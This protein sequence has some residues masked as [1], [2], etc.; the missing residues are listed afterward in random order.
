MHFWKSLYAVTPLGRPLTIS[1]QKD[2]YLKFASECVLES[3]CFTCF[4]IARARTFLNEKPSNMARCRQQRKY[5]V[6]M[7]N[8]CLSTIEENKA[9]LK[10]NKSKCYLFRWR[11]TIGVALILHLPTDKQRSFHTAM[12]PAH[13]WVGSLRS[14]ALLCQYNIQCFS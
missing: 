10:K 9:S 5:I 1:N 3:C 6:S 13:P 11:A 12:P 7:Q 14:T 4:F 8:G 2:K